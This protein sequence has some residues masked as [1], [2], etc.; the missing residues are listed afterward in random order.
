[1]DRSTLGISLPLHLR[2]LAHGVRGGDGPDEPTPQ[3]RLAAMRQFLES[4]EHRSR[5]SADELGAAHYELAVL[6]RSIQAGE[7]EGVDAHDTEVLRDISECIV[8]ACAEAAARY[9]AAAAAEAEITDLA[10]AAGLAEDETPEGGEP[11]GEGEPNGNEPGGEGEPK[12]EPGEGTEGEPAGD[13]GETP[14]AGE[15]EP[16]PEGAEGEP[17]LA[18]G[19]P[20]AALPSLAELRNRT[21]AARRDVPAPMAAV[22]EED[23]IIRWVPTNEMVS[24][25]E[26]LKRLAEYPSRFAGAIPQGQKLVLGTIELAGPDH[27][28]LDSASDS[29]EVMSRKLDR[30]VEGAL[31]PRNWGDRGEPS[32]ALVASGGWGTPSPVVYDV[33]TLAV[34]DRPVHD[35]LPSV[36]A[37]RGSLTWVRPPVLTD[38]VTGGPD[39]TGAAIGIITAAQDL[40]AAPPATDPRKSHQRVGQPTTD[41]VELDIQYSQL[42]KG[43]LQSRSFPEWIQ[44]WE[45]LTEAAWARMTETYVLDKIEA[46]VIT[47]SVTQAPVIGA[48]RDYLS[49]LSILGAGERNRQRM[50]PDAPLRVLYPATLIDRVQVDLIR[51]Q[52]H[53]VPAV[54][55]RAWLEA[56]LRLLNFNGS[57]YIDSSTAGAQLEPTQADSD[58]LNELRVRV[59][60]YVFH[61]GAFVLGQNGTLNLG[62]VR[63]GDLVN[64]NDFRVF[65]ET[66]EGVFDRGQFA[67]TL[68]TD[69]CPSGMTSGAV[70]LS[71]LCGGGS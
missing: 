23:A 22:H 7:V 38:I 10:R 24:R 4:E 18:G 21:P 6:F 46:S 3:E 8:A 43:V 58:D 19:T 70:D 41:T 48:A 69:L 27:Q 51:Q 67:F 36:T 49:F 2:V 53:D 40:A 45:R 60:S 71:G 13:E 63:D 20:R 9:A 34:S 50:R 29:A 56:Q 44:A 14:A 55:A 65:S 11:N 66:F 33:D 61:E 5:L 68:D 1:M 12:G 26:F 15:G 32:E 47:K 35:A 25:D 16:A 28:V 17:V 37:D 64:A 31:D 57:A 59:R 52:N 39:N 42:E 54:V 30:A 62:I